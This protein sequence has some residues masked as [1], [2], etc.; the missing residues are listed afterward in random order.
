M[1]AMPD[2]IKLPVRLTIGE[3]ALDL[4]TIDVPVRL[5]P[6]MAGEEGLAARVQLDGD[7]M[8]AKVAE[9]LE[10]AARALREGDDDAASDTR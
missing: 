8:N 5:G 3:G 1:G 9:L 7:A 10:L 2:T 4:G 6:P